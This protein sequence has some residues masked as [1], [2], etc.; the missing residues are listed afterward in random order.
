MRALVCPDVD[1]HDL[2]GDEGIGTT[3][4]MKVGNE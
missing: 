1:A 2:S 3:A 4:V